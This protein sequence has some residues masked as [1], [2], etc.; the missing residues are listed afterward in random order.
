MIISFFSTGTGG[1]AAP[2][3]YLT[4]REVLAYDENRNLLRDDTEQPPTK[5]R[6]P[7]P[8]VLHGNPDGLH[9]MPWEV[10]RLTERTATLEV[11][12]PSGHGG[13]TAN[14]TITAR[15]SLPRESV[16]RLEL[17]ATTDRPTL[18]NLTTHPNWTIGPGMGIAGQRL[19]IAADHILPIDADTRPTGERHAV[20]GTEYDFNIPR[21]LCLGAPDLDHKF[22]I[23]SARRETLHAAAT[24]EAEDGWSMAL[25]TTEPGLQV[26]DGRT[27]DA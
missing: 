17:S 19:Q 18:M 9:A 15:Y 20:A 23:A 27:T 4:A 6:Y 16:V 2:V 7:L 11:T 14:R 8:E 1:G 5:V 10:T 22:C 12:L 25:W 24:L 3:D 21:A 26:Y 13:F